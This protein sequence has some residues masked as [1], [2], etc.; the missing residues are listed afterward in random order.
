MAIVDF[1]KTV[2]AKT[3][4]HVYAEMLTRLRNFIFNEYD[5]M[6]LKEADL[7]HDHFKKLIVGR[8]IQ[9]EKVKVDDLTMTTMGMSVWSACLER[10]KEEYIKMLIRDYI[11]KD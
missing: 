4:Q 11:N 1:R 8:F 9:S 2:E 3:N 7:L 5:G 6:G 10:S